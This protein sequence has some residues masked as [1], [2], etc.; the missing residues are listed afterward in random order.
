M[1]ISE[2]RLKRIKRREIHEELYDILK[3][4]GYQGFISIEMEKTDNM[5][6]VEEVLQYV[7]SIFER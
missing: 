3:I 2:P 1:F 7:N 6:E 4:E 5:L